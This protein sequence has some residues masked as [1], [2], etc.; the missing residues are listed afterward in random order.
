MATATPS[1][2][3]LRQILDFAVEI[4]HQA[5]RTTLAYFQ[6][7]FE[8]ETKTDSTPVTIADRSAEQLLRSRIERRF[9]GH[10]ILGEEYGATGPAGA[11][12]RWILDP[13]DGTRSF[14]HGVPLYATLIG[15]EV[16]GDPAVGVAYFPALDEMV[17]A[18]RGLGAR[19][20]GR[21]CRVSSTANLAGATF[22]YTSVEGFLRQGRQGALDL[23]VG[24]TSVQRGW[25]DAYA[26]ALVATG[27]ID[28]AVEPVMNIWDNAPLLPILEEAGGRFTDWTG[29]PRIDGGD[30][31]STNGLLH[32]A[33]LALLDGQSASHLQ[34]G[35]LESD[36]SEGS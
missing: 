33:V 27:R 26:H 21:P 2:P 34:P 30:A 12:C 20:N 6:A 23:L 36:G 8:V 19:W 25:G 13:V 29:A 28:L 16:D 5:G 11:S 22:C 3:G 14:V 18:A 10:A 32:D 31:L 9:P 4:A 7:S 35:R 17:H 24:A 1:A 15:V